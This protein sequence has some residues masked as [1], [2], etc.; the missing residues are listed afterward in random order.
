MADLDFTLHASERCNC[1]IPTGPQDATLCNAL[2]DV[3]TESG[4]R[5]SVCFAEYGGK[6]VTATLRP[7]S[8]LWIRANIK[9][10]ADLDGRRKGV[11]AGTWLYSQSFNGRGGEL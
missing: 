7:I 8:P 4:P 6:L 10:A 3:L 2:A 1:E 9:A 5:C 11:N